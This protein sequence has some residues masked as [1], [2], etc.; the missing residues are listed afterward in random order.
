MGA[1]G[2]PAGPG[3]PSGTAAPPSPATQPE[4]AGLFLVLPGPL[5]HR[6]PEV[7]PSHRGT[8]GPTFPAPPARSCPNPAILPSLSFHPHP[9]HSI[10]VPTLAPSPAHPPPRQTPQ[11]LLEEGSRGMNEAAWDPPPPI[12]KAMGLGHMGLSKPPVLGARWGGGEWTHGGTRPRCSH[13]AELS[14]GPP[15]PPTC[16]HVALRAGLSPDA[17]RWPGNRSRPHQQ[18]HFSCFSVSQDHQVPVPGANVPPLSRPRCS[19]LWEEAPSRLRQTD[20]RYW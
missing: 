6:H 18:S 9:S 2:V 5:R 7:A 16:T 14:H 17:P 3:A 15:L 10:P 12:T 4:G 11:I 19:C 1:G 8:P 20:P 13:P